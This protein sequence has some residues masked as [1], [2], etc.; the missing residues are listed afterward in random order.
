MTPQ[1][2]R[3]ILL[4]SLTHALVHTYELAWPSIEQEATFHFFPD[5][6]ELAK[7]VSGGLAGLWR[8]LFGGGSLLVGWL[9]TR[10]SAFH[11][12][13]AYLL[14]C[15]ACSI[16]A[17]LAPNPW[18]LAAGLAGTGAFAAIYHPAG[19]GLIS[20]KTRPEERPMALGI[21]GI[22]G[23]LGIAV[24][25][26]WAG[27]WLGAGGTW[28]T[29]LIGLA[30]PGVILAAVVI[31]MRRQSVGESKE[32]E[33]H[34]ADV[35]E[36]TQSMNVGILVLIAGIAATQGFVYSAQLSF[37]PRYLSTGALGDFNWLD[38]YSPN[39]QG[40][41]LAAAALLLGCL[42]QF[43]AGYFARHRLLEPQLLGVLLLN[44]P[45]LLAM[46][47]ADGI[48]R[49]IAAGGFALVHFMYQPVY[50]SLVAKRVTP[51]YRSFAFG[52]SFAISLGLGFLGSIFASRFQEDRPLFCSL[53]FVTFVG[54]LVALTLT[55]KKSESRREGV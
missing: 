17:G 14:G 9:I 20:Q 39:E 28:R 8:L 10:N 1:L 32:E 12:L 33:D 15:A 42:G 27:L 36:S 25:P 16:V 43:V 44:I 29:Y 51:R 19:L 11:W 41:L 34:K 30:V 21:H 52:A 18:V 55:L 3:V 24:A 46:G 40:K 4:I 50:N 37:L 54:S 2:W 49:L 5:D 23:S 26:L 38:G 7:R 53:A 13:T 6:P 31:W 22:L 47:F 48:W 45:F 35:D